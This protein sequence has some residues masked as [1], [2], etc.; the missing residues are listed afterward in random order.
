MIP[1]A[2]AT[3]LA[4]GVA[5]SGCRFTGVSSLP[6][7]GGVDT[8]AHPLEVKMVFENVL[9]LVPQ[10][11][12]RVN[13]VPVGM[14]TKIS[15]V[16]WKAVV[17]CKLRSSVDLPANAVAAIS[18]TSLLGEKYVALSAP[19][20]Q[21]PQ[22]RLA[23]GAEIPLD[24]TS[25]NTEVEEVLS[26]MSMLVT[27]GGLE[28]VSTITH[29][30]NAALQGHTEQLRDVLGRLNTF[31]GTL[32]RQKGQIVTTI[33]KV[34]KLSA[35]LAKHNKTIADTIDSTGPAVKVLASQRKDLTKLLV[36]MDKLGTVATRIINRSQGD[37]VANLKALQQILD[38]TN[39]ASNVIPKIL[40]GL[41]TFPFPQ[42]VSQALKGDY[43]NLF[44]SLDLNVGDIAH[45]F[46]AGTPLEGVS[47]AADKL[48]NLLPPPRTS[49][50]DTPLGVL[51]SL[52][53]KGGAGTGG[54][55]G[56]GGSGGSG[57]G[58]GGILP[59]LGMSGPPGDDLG[60]LLKGGTA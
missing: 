32:D 57:G 44:I 10:S 31:V 47:K 16:D 43:G 8:G 37:T 36:N 39:K 46:L 48:Q 12:C 34:D 3:V 28:Q 56:T 29:E 50:P 24:R 38:N 1:R 11:Q 2:L 22:G 6:L 58:L 33:D 40:G 51:P 45:N 54:T 23:Q 13:D 49:V 21:T 41:F 9:D 18:Q 52:T 7:P 30:L 14:V 59:P 53:G 17:T 60:A 4:L 15:L 55:G 25:R 5:V 27:G 26:A 20:G 42:T 19:Q 35:T